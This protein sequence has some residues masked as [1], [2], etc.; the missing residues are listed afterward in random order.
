MNTPIDQSGASSLPALPVGVWKLVSY[1]TQDPE[2]GEMFHP[3]GPGATGYLT[4]TAGGHM[5]AILQAGERP[6]FSAGN[7]INAP[8]AERARA[9]SSS[10]TYAGRYTWQGDRVIHHVEVSSNPDWV[11]GDQLRF[12][13]VDGKRLTITTPPLPTRPDGKLRVSTLVWERVE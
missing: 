3:F 2:S 9:F 1:T 10:T 11:G 7:R 12:P 5:S 6:R 4:Y 8:E 13:S